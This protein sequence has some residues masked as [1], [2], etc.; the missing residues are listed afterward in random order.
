[1]AHQLI[2]I[3]G[4]FIRLLAIWHPLACPQSTHRPDLSAACVDAV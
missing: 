4:D 1:M 2:Q 3:G